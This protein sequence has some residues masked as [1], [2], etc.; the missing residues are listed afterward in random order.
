MMRAKNANAPGPCLTPAKRACPTTANNKMQRNRKMTAKRNC[1]SERSRLIRGSASKT[2]TST[3]DSTIN[4]GEMLPVDDDRSALVFP[5]FKCQIQYRR[6]NSEGTSNRID[7]KSGGFGPY[8]KLDAT[9][10]EQH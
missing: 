9:H 8:S 6:Q 3:H 5:N 10:N 2:N 7:W 1:P 4:G